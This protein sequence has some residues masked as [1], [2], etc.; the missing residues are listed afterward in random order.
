MLP[1]IGELRPW[2]DPST[3]EIGRLPSRPRRD[4]TSSPWRRSLDGEWSLR[5]WDIPDQVGARALTGS[6]DWRRMAT[7]RRRTRQ[8]DDAGN[9]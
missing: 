1:V 6:A 3:I 2:A 5:L 9:E 8:L 4:D 7:S